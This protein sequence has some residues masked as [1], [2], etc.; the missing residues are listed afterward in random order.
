MTPELLEKITIVDEPEGKVGDSIGLVDLD[1]LE[2]PGEEPKPVATTND[3]WYY[4]IPSVGVRYYMY[5]SS[6]QSPSPKAK[7]GALIKCSK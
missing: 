3:H 5:E 2:L 7:S 1:A 4:R 6:D